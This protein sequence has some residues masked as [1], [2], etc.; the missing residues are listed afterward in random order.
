MLSRRQFLG[1][2]AALPT[3]FTAQSK[4][5]PNVVFILGDDLGYADLGCYGQRDIQTPNLD[6]LAGEG[7]RFTNAYAGSTVCGPS[8][9]CL[10]TGRH[11]G[12]ATIRGNLLPEIPLSQSDVTIAQLFKRA[13][14]RTGAFGKWG[15]GT[16]PDMHALPTRKG[17]DT[18]Y[19]YL[20][21]VHAHTYFPDMLWDNEHETY[22]PPNFGGGKKRYSHDLIAERA[23]KFIDDNRDQPFFLYAPFTLPHGRFE[24]PD[25]APYSGKPWPPAARTL[26]SMVTRLDQTVGQ[27]VERLKRHRLERDTLV[28]FASDNGPGQLGVEHFKANGPLRGYK[29][30]LYEGGIRCPFITR[31]AGRIQPAVSEE[32]FAFWDLLPSFA[33]LIGQPAPANI[34]G[35]SVLNALL[36]KGPA[37]QTDRHFY[38]EFHERGFQQAVRWRNWKA[39][40]LKDGG[41]AGAPIEL[42]DLAADQGETTDLARQRTDIAVRLIQ[43]MDSSRSPSPHWPVKSIAPDQSASRG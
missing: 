37:P 27:I 25:D 19:G 3:Q 17:F 16:I 36:G 34:D 18:F 20:H 14:Y 4:R 38:W 28:V 29:R 26:A 11:T 42:Y 35:V 12:H 8:R 39:V 41:K 24:A 6:A 22:L 2:T 7:I 21:Q 15:M 43:L 10:M 30:D 9:C 13:G 5:Q 31:W 23:L 32:V 40:R 1:T 33:R